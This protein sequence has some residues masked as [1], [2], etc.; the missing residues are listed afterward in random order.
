MVAVTG[1]QHLVRALVQ[2]HLRGIWDI[3]TSRALGA[4]VAAGSLPW[5]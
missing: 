3:S 2:R 5:S 4:L 1:L